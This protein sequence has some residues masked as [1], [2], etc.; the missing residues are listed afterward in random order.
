MRTRRTG[1]EVKRSLREV[2]REM[3]KG[4][5]ASDVCRKAGIAPTT[6]DRRRAHHDPAQADSDRRCR[7]LEAE[8]ERLKRIVAESMLDERRLQDLAKKQW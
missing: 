4:L 7:E 1:E 8:V 3:A 2:A 5:T 6:Y